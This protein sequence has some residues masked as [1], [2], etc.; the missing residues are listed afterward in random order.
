MNFF[1]LLYHHSLDIKNTLLVSLFMNMKEAANLSSKFTCVHQT[2]RPWLNDGNGLQQWKSHVCLYISTSTFLYDLLY[3]CHE[4]EL[5]ALFPFFLNKKKICWGWWSWW[6]DDNGKWNCDVVLQHRT[7]IYLHSFVFSQLTSFLSRGWRF[8]E[9]T[10]SAHSCFIT[11][12]T[13]T[14]KIKWNDKCSYFCHKT[15]QTRH[16]F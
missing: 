6:A 11:G 2:K 7:H 8:H 16:V 13:L 14:P 5:C 4:K 3:Y 1:I 12:L 10:L 9:D 15:L